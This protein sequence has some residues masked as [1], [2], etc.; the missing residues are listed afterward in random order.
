MTPFLPPDILTEPNDQEEQPEP[1]PLTGP[2][3]LVEDDTKS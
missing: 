3:E 1:T 2:R